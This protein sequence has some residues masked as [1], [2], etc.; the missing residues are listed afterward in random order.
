VRACFVPKR[1]TSH[2]IL[3]VFPAH[4]QIGHHDGHGSLSRFC[5]WPQIATSS[6]PYVRGLNQDHLQILCW[7][8]LSHLQLPGPSGSMNSSSHRLQ[9]ETVE[10]LCQ[11]STLHGAGKLTQPN[12]MLCNAILRCRMPC[13][14]MPEGLQDSRI[15]AQK[16]GMPLSETEWISCHR[17]SRLGLT[18]CV[19]LD[20]T[21]FEGQCPV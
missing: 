17:I 9:K 15:S 21:S 4:H 5:T 16:M 13:H 8:E 7:R 2:H 10:K 12:A 19:E 20:H 11:G 14:A 18:R 1:K 6:V 3:I